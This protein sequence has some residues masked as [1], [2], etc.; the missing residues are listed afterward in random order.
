MGH[1]K[2]RWRYDND[3]PELA[4][5]LSTGGFS[6]AAMTTGLLL[7]KDVSRHDHSDTVGNVESRFAAR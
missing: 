7:S 2:L 1:I 3:N 4:A 6:K 5:A